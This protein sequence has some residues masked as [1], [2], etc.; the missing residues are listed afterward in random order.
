MNI[1]KDKFPPMFTPEQI[2]RI[3]NSQS[4]FKQSGFEDDPLPNWCRH[5]GHNFPTHLCI[6][7]GKKYRHVCPACGNE[8]VVSGNG[9]PSLKVP[10]YEYI[11]DGTN[12]DHIIELKEIQSRN[13]LDS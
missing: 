3:I 4:K 5:P 7:V 11:S 10:D 12:I 9:K 6:P 8:I 1:P 2:E 13:N